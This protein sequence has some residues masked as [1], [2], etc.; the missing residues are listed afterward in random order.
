M[1]SELIDETL[2]RIS[3]AANPQLAQEVGA[4]WDSL[5]KPPGSLGKLERLLLHAALIQ[6]RVF[7][8]LERKG[9][10]VFCGD[11]G[12]VEQG[13]TA[14]PSD[15]TRQM[16]TN[17]LSGG[18]AIN[19]LCRHYGIH[20][21]V[22]DMGVKGPAEPAAVDLKIAEGT[23]DFSTGPAMTRAQA[24]QA[25]EHGIELAAVAVRRYD[26]VGIGEMGIGNSTSAAALL[27]AFSGR[28]AEETVGM[29]AGIGPGGIEKKRFVVKQALLLHRDATDPI[30]M[31][32]AV[33]GF[34]IAG[35]AG[36]LL[37]AAAE[38]LIVVVDGF[39]SSSAALVAKA[40]A[41]D[42]LDAAIF[43][44]RSAEH[45]HHLMLDF[46]GVQP[47]FDLDL[48]LGEGTGSAIAMGLMDAANLL[49]T[50]MAT[51]DSAQVDGGRSAASNTVH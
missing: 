10:F 44:H 9:M 37:G 41:P 30:A 38:R 32:A 20:P 8:L 22:V 16:V 36:F 4:R 17:F 13:V 23:A 19:V 18:A 29:G 42:A 15:V 27:S 25:V 34:E 51:F 14:F 48:R 2:R 11:H 49:Y 40:L 45:A 35:M 24:V 26:I 12:V 39:I 46:L 7:P 47:Q 1:I 5:T 28:S 33:G 21:V 6:N 31:L 43:S 50:Q 3:P